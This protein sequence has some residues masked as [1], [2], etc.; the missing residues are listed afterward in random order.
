[1][2]NLQ[3]SPLIAL[4]GVCRYTKFEALFDGD[5]SVT[6]RTAS[7]DGH[8]QAEGSSSTR[9]SVHELSAKQVATVAAVVRARERTAAASAAVA[10]ADSKGSSTSD[11][12]D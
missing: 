12:V 7:G 9:G 10:A 4:G 1:M 2:T 3:I 11:A 6:K 8:S 5:P